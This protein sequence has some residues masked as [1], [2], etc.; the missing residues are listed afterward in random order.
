MTKL[1]SFLLFSVTAFAAVSGTVTNGTTGKPQ[2][3][4]TVT[5]YKFGQGG[6]EPADSVKTDAQGSFT[7]TKDPQTPGP[8][9]VRIEIDGVTYNKMMPPGTPT[10]GLTIDVYN[11]SKEP[12]AAKVSKHMLLFEPAGDQMTVNETLLVSNSGKTTWAD[13]QSG[14]IRFFMPEGAANLDAKG[15]AP[16]GMPVPI[17][18]DKTGKANIYAAKFECKP[19]ETR[20]DLTYT[21]PYKTGA[22]YEGKIA[23]DDENSYLIAPNGVTLQGDGLKDLG[24]EPR[25]QAHIYGL[26]D[27]SYKITLTGAEAAAPSDASADQPD[28]SGPQIEEIMPRVYGQKWAILGLALGILALG[29][30]L[31]YR[32]QP[33]KETHERGSR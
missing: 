9:M 16:D 17:P 21:V 28:S 33:A 12:G 13:P 7:F 5:L 18:T 4:T 19:G 24:T 27:K 14:T 30:V 31:L 23:S 32:S 29:F 8:K 26:A 25:T 15:T 1:G 22:A 10:T 3:N 20:F 6:M 11:A 2:A